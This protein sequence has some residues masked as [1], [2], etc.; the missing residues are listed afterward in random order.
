VP[1]AGQTYAA[2][3]AA[4]AARPATQYPTYDSTGHTAYAYTPAS[5]VPRPVSIKLF[6]K[7]NSNECST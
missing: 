6:F 3:P 1:S 5:A 2:T 4:A 7:S